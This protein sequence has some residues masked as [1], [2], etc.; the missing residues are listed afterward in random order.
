[1]KKKKKPSKKRSLPRKKSGAESGSLVPLVNVMQKLLAPGGCPWDR[2][3]THKTLAPYAIEEAFELADAIENGKT[4][5]MKEEL[6]DFLFQVVF[7]AELA[8]KEGI[9]TL[10]EVVKTVSDKLIHRHPHVFGTVEVKN[11]EE[12]L[13][14]WDKIKQAEKK[15]KAKSVFE[16]PVALPALQRAQKIGQKTKNLKFDWN[17]ATEVLQKVEEEFAELKEAL[18]SGESAHI[19]EELGDVFFVL[20]QLARHLQLEAETVARKGNQKFEKRFEKLLQLAKKKNLDFIP[21][22]TE[23]KEKLWEEV[24]RK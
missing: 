14:N 24:K 5:D 12:V 17:N 11:S 15:N 4:E 10:D 1:M 8:R 2:E 16:I 23:E 6:G 13:K 7:H 20:A 18:N 21:L 22:P 9:F 19:E 3:Q